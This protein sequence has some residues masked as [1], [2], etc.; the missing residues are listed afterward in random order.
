MI[1]SQ[2]ITKE[3]LY[4]MFYEEKTLYGQVKSVTGNQW[5][6]QLN[7]GFSDHYFLHP[8]LL[9]DIMHA[10]GCMGI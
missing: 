6:N 8:Q 10:E 5:M 4:G 9:L 2:L 7:N 3:N 1:L